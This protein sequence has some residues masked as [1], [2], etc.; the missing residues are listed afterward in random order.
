MG[1]RRIEVQRH[2]HPGGVF[3]KHINARRLLEYTT[4]ARCGLNCR[5]QIITST[6]RH[7]HTHIHST[8]RGKSGGEYRGRQGWAG[9]WCHCHDAELCS[10][11]ERYFSGGKG[12]VIR[13]AS[14][15]PPFWPPP[16]EAASQLSPENHH[17]PEYVR[18][19]SDKIYKWGQKTPFMRGGRDSELTCHNDQTALC[20]S[21]QMFPCLKETSAWQE[22]NHHTDFCLNHSCLHKY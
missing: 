9:W 1:D 17:G 6:Y 2:I 4:L 20:V 10:G 14:P 7:I 19:S 15:R 21:E 11:P 16:S 5:Q 12:G 13:S 8:H 22:Q 3:Y 18:G